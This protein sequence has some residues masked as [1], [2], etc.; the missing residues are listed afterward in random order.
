M[1]M[2]SVT[3]QLNNLAPPSGDGGDAMQED[4]EADAEADDAAA[5]EAK[6]AAENAA[7]AQLAAAI[8]P[9]AQVVAGGA[10]FVTEIDGKF[11]VRK[12][13]GGSKYAEVYAAGKCYLV[14]YVIGS[15]EYKFAY[16]EQTKAPIGKLN[17]DI[18]LLSFNDDREPVTV[19][20][21][22]TQAAKPGEINSAVKIHQ[23]VEKRDKAVGKAEVRAERDAE[24]AGLD[25]QKAELEHDNANFDK[26]AAARDHDQALVRLFLPI[27]SG[28]NF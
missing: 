7:R 13:T 23:A 17:N 15:P 21:S 27:S 6:Q 18:G 1:A 3:E 25:V 10:E 24:L 4:Y 20:L 28:V 9:A 11:T 8:P 12:Y 19:S 2:V 16:D 5:L 14:G 26:D 22:E